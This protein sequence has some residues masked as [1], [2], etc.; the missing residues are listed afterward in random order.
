[1]KKPS[2]LCLLLLT[3]VTQAFAQR[4][5]VSGY[6]SDKETGETLISATI[7]DSNST[8]GATSNNF[9]H[10]SLTL[11]TGNVT[12]EYSYLGYKTVVQS[13]NMQS[14]T[15]LNIHLKQSNLLEEVTVVGNRRESWV[16]GSQMSKVDVS[17][18]GRAHV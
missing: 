16:K 10:Y 13:F 17:K 12:L 2:L 6:I 8:K 15:V 1:M 11:P 4:Y 5:T 14:D 3:I 9:G 7:F 18:I